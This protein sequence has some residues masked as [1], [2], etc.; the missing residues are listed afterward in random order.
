M[1][2]RKHVKDI[3]EYE[4][5]AVDS[6]N[7]GVSTARKSDKEKHAADK[8]KNEAKERATRLGKDLENIRME[9]NNLKDQLRDSDV[10]F[11]SLKREIEHLKRQNEIMMEERI[12]EVSA[13]KK[14]YQT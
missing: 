5:L 1:A 14:P 6:Y 11:K 8:L 12:C 13:L 4:K 3:K 10:N 2:A 7:E 9:R